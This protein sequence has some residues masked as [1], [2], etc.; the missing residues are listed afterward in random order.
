MLQKIE[1]DPTLGPGDDPGAG[2]VFLCR[3]NITK[4]STVGLDECV[5]CRTAD[6]H[7]N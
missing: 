3:S 1:I 7:G 4:A 6:M 2:Q 5:V